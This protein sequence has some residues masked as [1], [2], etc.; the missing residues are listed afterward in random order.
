MFNYGKHEK[1][2]ER[3]KEEKKF[4]YSN[5]TDKTIFWVVFASLLIVGALI[6]LFVCLYHFHLF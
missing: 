1:M 4:S 6:A 2:R 3:P 5:K